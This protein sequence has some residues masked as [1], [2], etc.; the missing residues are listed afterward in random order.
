MKIGR[1][2]AVIAL[3]EKRIDSGEIAENRKAY[4]ERGFYAF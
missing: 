1:Q 2:K 4:I 3:K